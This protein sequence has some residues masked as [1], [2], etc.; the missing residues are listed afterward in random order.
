[1][2]WR[3]EKDEAVQITCEQVWLGIESLS[4]NLNCLSSIEL[5]LEVEV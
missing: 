4:R 2:T 3:L 1:M 5:S